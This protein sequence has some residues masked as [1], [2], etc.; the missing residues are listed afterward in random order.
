MMMMMM[1]IIII[2]IIIIS[3]IIICNFFVIS[4]WILFRMGNI[5]D[6][7]CRE[8]QSTHFT[9]N[10]SSQKSCSLWDNVQKY[11]TDRQAADGNII[12]CMRFACWI[13]KATKNTCNAYS[14]STST[15]VSPTRLKDTLTRSLSV[16][17]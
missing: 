7:I 15:M 2:I 10:I 11:V 5:S 9:C 4:L 12:M 8:N 14:F 17:L 6:K 16:L 13:T 1:M 3:K